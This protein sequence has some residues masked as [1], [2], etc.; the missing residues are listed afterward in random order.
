ME[1]V[2]S[3]PMLVKAIEK[4]MSSRQIVEVALENGYRPMLQNG[5]E[6]IRA[7]LTSIAELE[8]ISLSAVADDEEP[9]A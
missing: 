3:S 2:P 9:E 1:M 7:G 8:T 4:N 5:V 6:M